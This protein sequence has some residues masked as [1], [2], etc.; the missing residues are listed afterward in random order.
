MNQFSPPSVLDKNDRS[1][2]HVMVDRV[3]RHRSPGRSHVESDDEVIVESRIPQ[4]YRT[5]FSA[6]TRPSRRER[7][8]SLSPA[9]SLKNSRNAS[10]SSRTRRTLSTPKHVTY[11]SV[12]TVRHSATFDTVYSSDTQF[13]DTENITSSSQDN[14]IC[15]NSSQLDTDTEFSEQL[16]SVSRQI[17]KEYSS[18]NSRYVSV[19]TPNGKTPIGTSLSKMGQD[20][21][22][23]VIQKDYTHDRTISYRKAV[24][25]EGFDENAEKS[26]PKLNIVKPDD[27]E[28]INTPHR[29]RTFS[30]NLGNFFRRISP[31][32]SRRRSKDREQ[33]SSAQSLTSDNSLESD[34]CKHS[35]RGSQEKLKL[36]LQKLMGRPRSQSRS[37][38]KSEKNTK[39]SI[40]NSL[41]NNAPV[42]DTTKTEVENEIKS[43][44]SFNRILKSIEQNSM[45]EKAVYQK[46]KEKQM[47]HKQGEVTI[48]TMPTGKPVAV[49]LFG[50]ENSQLVSDSKMNKEN[51]M[52]SIECDRSDAEEDLN[53]LSPR[54][55]DLRRNDF[56]LLSADES[57][58]NCSLDVNYTESDVSTL[59]VTNPST[60]SCQVVSSEQEFM[61]DQSPAMSAT[62]PS[63]C[64]GQPVLSLSDSAI[65]VDSNTHSVSDEFNSESYTRLPSYLKLSRAC[66]GYGHYNRYSWYKNIEK[67]SPYSSLTSLPS[68][69]SHELP[70]VVS[71]KENNLSTES[72]SNQ[73]HVAN[74][75]SKQTFVNERLDSVY[76]TGDPVKDGNYFLE[77]TQIEEDRLLLLISR[78]ERD[79][80]GE[81]LSE[82]VYGKMRAAV[83][84]ANLLIT[85]KFQQ[86]RELCALHM[87]PSETDRCAK[88]EDLQGFWDMV[89][90]QVDSVDEMFIELDFMKQNDWKEINFKSHVSSN[91]SSPKSG[92]LSLSNASTPSATPGHTPGSKRKVLKVKDT[93]DG[94][95]ERSEKAKQTAKVREEARKRMLA[96]RRAVMKQKAQEASQEVEIFLPTANNS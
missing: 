40:P 65:V 7:C 61:S 4:P 30:N 20:R 2:Q 3:T 21:G 35:R 70:V 68:V 37:E 32:L 19:Q 62:M 8:R 45:T 69:S 42:P 56:S 5:S 17:Q 10:K 93:V 95:P 34:T 94:S 28:V 55:S 87:N 63:V 92:S 16:R 78:T 6:V 75:Y 59:N 90:I 49:K 81:D 64:I 74:G 1:Y 25:N 24:H 71:S 83:G 85:Q 73:E 44:P 86:F 14:S 51:K 82:E 66:S 53:K 9:S 57:I 46:F 26:S 50:S 84:K 76:P 15:E 18:T 89:K 54:Q 27:P 91:N 29:K 36:S 33:M 80:G 23:K 38:S 11:D 41:S 13:T 79:M 39:S 96:E 12:V 43:S 48:T 22:R 60:T 47:P 31:R 67:R 72:S 88:W 52:L 77:V 58:G